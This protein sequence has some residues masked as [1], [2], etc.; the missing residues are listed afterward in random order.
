MTVDNLITIKGGAYNDVKKALGQWIDLYANDLQDR[1]TF[2]LFKNGLGNHIIQVDERLD[3]ERFYYLVN[4]LNSPEGI[5]YKIDIVGFITGREENKLKNKNLLVHISPTDEDYDNV[6]V[7][8][9]EN[10]N[11]KVQFGVGIIET[12]E[13]KTFKLPADLTFNAPETIVFDKTQKLQEEEDDRSN[14]LTKRFKIVFAIV[15]TAYILAVLIFNSTES[16]LEANGLI[17]FAIWTWLT[18]D[19]KILQIDKL[20]FGSVLLGVII[21]IYGC[22]LR[23]EFSPDGESTRV[24]TE[25]AMPILF[26]ILQRPLRFAFKGIM[27]REPVVDKP[28]PSFADFVYIFILMMASLLIPTLYYPR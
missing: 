1:L 22:F 3:N 5:D 2:Q 8:T 4:Y 28:A 7:T 9:S 13:K 18:F 26:L 15:L 23:N 16:F 14:K 20:Y 10:E 17:T 27:K 19:Y 12:S 21:F 6:F 11:F 24:A 25:T